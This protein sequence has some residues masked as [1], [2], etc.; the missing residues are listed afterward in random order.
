MYLCAP[1]ADACFRL[2]G[3]TGGIS[4]SGVDP[5]WKRTTTLS[6]ILREVE[7]ILYKDGSRH[8]R[9]RDPHGFS[10][11]GES[12]RLIVGLPT[13]EPGLHRL[14]EVH[15]VWCGPPGQINEDDV[16]DLT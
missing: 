3:D 6:P 4:L 9:G 1:G 12:N 14:G 11:C 5:Q 8:H 15:R 13:T 7:D 2:E 16:V 10:M